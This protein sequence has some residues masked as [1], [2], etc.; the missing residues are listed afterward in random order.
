MACAV[1]L[2]DL[3][4][5]RIGND[6]YVEEHGSYGLTTLLKDHVRKR[7]RML[8]FAFPGKGGIEHEIAIDDP[9]A[10]AVIDRLRRRRGGGEELL[11]YKDGRVWRDVNAEGVNAYLRKLFGGDVTAK[12]FRTWHATVLAAV[13]LADSTEPADSKRGRQRAIRQTLVEVAEYLGNTPAVA[14]SAYVDPRVFDLYEDGTTIARAL[15]RAPKRPAR[16]QEHLER[17]VLRMLT[18]AARATD[19]AVVTS[20]PK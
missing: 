19:R 13:A 15:A 2:M 1:R 17:A 8:V 12:D 10:S 7:D 16:S 11:A 18:R 5:F 6:E 14:R 3:G 4:Y 20:G 9:A